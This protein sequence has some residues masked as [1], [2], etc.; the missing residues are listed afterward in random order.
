MARDAGQ[1]NAKQTKQICWFGHQQFSFFYRKAFWQLFKKGGKKAA[2]QRGPRD[3][4]TCL[5]NGNAAGAG[6]FVYVIKKGH[7][8]EV[9][10]EQPQRWV[11]KAAEL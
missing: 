11:I 2:E 1:G 10:H 5:N 4:R 6:G 8:F 9:T 3:L 7:S